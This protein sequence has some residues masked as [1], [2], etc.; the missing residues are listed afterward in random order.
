MIS[1]LDRMADQD[2]QCILEEAVAVEYNEEAG[3]CADMYERFMFNATLVKQSLNHDLVLTN[4]TMRLENVF[5]E[6]VN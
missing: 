4:P 5:Q 2:E 6:Q 1:V 3:G